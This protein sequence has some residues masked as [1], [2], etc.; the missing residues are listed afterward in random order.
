MSNNLPELVDIDYV[1]AE[2][3]VEDSAWLARDVNPYLNFLRRLKPPSRETLRF[4]LQQVA[5]IMGAD[6]VPLEEIMWHKLK[7][8]HLQAMVSKLDALGYA[9]KTCALYLTAIRGVINEAHY[10]NLIP[11]FEVAGIRSVKPFPQNRLPVG[12]FVEDPVI[13]ALLED[14]A[15]DTRY[16]GVRDAAIIS[17][18][19]G[20]GLR[21]A[22][23]VAVDIS[24]VNQKE[25]SLTVIGKGDKEMKKWIAPGAAS[26]MKTW[27]EL[28]NRFC[29]ESGP[30]FTRIRKGRKVRSP[31]DDL[32]PM[33]PGYTPGAITSD[34][35]T[36]MAIYFILKE[37]STK[38]GFH[39]K[40]HDLRRTFVTRMIEKHGE[41]MAK[42]LAD[43]SNLATTLKYDMRGDKQKQAAMQDEN[44]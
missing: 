14:C 42:M 30:L 21:R 38:L 39:V 7:R 9:H 19:Y 23:S 35:L 13:K 37:R 34:G 16:Q 8:S 11:S 43:H 5:S 12:Q 41:G 18:L 10:A 22:E 17:L 32:D 26:R 36:P 27:I 44:F 31:V 29:E 1:L 6:D 15:Q 3:D 25:W 40:P 2:T 28:R 4:C 20:C 24:K 33:R